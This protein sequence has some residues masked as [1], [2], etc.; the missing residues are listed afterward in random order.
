MGKNLKGRNKKRLTMGKNLLRKYNRELLRYADGESN[1]YTE[2]KRSVDR[3][4]VLFC[5]C[6][7][8]SRADMTLQ[9]VDSSCCKN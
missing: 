1:R 3:G 5:K 7:T 2:V 8:N 6:C 9:K 4:V